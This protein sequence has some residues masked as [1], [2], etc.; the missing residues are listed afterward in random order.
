MLF[1][2]QGD[3]CTNCGAP[4]LRSFITFDVLPLVEFELEPGIT[5]TE[6]QVRLELNMHYWAVCAQQSEE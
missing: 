2:L 1:C 6:A 4:F 5:D 3:F